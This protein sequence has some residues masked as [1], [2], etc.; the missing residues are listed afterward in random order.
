[1]LLTP[2][3]VV[4]PAEAVVCEAEV[5]ALGSTWH[6]KRCGE[7]E[8]SPDHRQLLETRL[9]IALDGNQ[10]LG[11]PRKKTTTDPLPVRVLRPRETAFVEAVIVLSLHEIQLG[12][13]AVDRVIRLTNH[14]L[15]ILAR[16]RYPEVTWVSDEQVEREKRKFI[17]RPEDG[18]PATKSELLREIRKGKRER[19]QAVG[20]PSEYQ[21]TGLDFLLEIEPADPK[22]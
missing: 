13:V 21:L 20:V 4:R 19:G 5:I 3:V 9:G 22:T 18:K 11:I 15:V 10:P 8:L 1:M 6:R 17:G 14:Q 2:P 16:D 12:R 7:I